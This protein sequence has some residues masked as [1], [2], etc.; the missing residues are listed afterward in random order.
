MSKSTAVFQ[1]E[2]VHLDLDPRFYR[3]VKA[4]SF[5][6]HQLRYRNLEAAQAVGLERLSSVEW[7]QHFSHFTPLPGSLPE[8]LALCYHG[9]QFGHYNPELGDGRGF[10]FAQLRDDAGRLL[11]LGTKGSG[12]TPF[13]RT[14]DGRLTLKG[15]VREIL[16]T[17][18]LEALGVNT[19]RSFSVFETGEA[20][21]RHDEPS[22]TRSAVLV[23]LSHSHIRIGSFQRLAYLDDSEGLEKLA[24]HVARHYYPALSGDS[25]LDADAPLAGLLPDLLE[26]VMLAIAG[27]VGQW[28]GSGF[29]HGVLNTDN[30]NITGESFDYGPW[31]FLPQFDPSLVAAYFDQTGRYAYGRQS[32]AALWAVCRLADCFLQLVEKD[33][34]EAR[35]FGFYPAVEDS[36]TRQVCWRL[37]VCFGAADASV[38]KATVRAL[39]V[40]AKQS[41]YGFDQIF[42]DLYGGDPRC[43]GYDSDIWKPVL[44]NLAGATSLR[45]EALEHPHFAAAKAVS[46]TIDEVEAIWAPIASDDDWHPLAVKIAQIRQMRAALSGTAPSIMPDIIGGAIAPDASG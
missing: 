20:L 39:F 12:T 24:R 6:C 16:A 37:G 3:P 26:K 2:T 7:S 38:A 25:G 4:A 8:P 41:Q 43:E 31:R 17:E 42:H 9:H 10:L 28:L 34:L 11:D 40:A 45:P 33:Q 22:P 27:T 18:M 44:D 1:P 46:M 36:L 14:A 5:P 23:R 13:S 29:V 35:L 30:F 21:T 32:E 15:A 19:S